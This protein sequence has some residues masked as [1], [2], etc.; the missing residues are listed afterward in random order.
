MQEDSRN[1]RYGSVVVP[2]SHVVAVL[3]LIQKE[4]LRNIRLSATC[5]ESYSVRILHRW[6]DSRPPR[7]N[8][9]P[10]VKSGWWSS[11]LW[12]TFMFVPPRQLKWISANSVSL[13]ACFNLPTSSA[14]HPAIQM[15]YL[16][17]QPHGFRRSRNLTVTGL[18]QELHVVC[19]HRHPGS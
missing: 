17:R 10:H 15:S 8:S 2:V 9:R 7:V 1:N 6:Y 19:I 5:R 16:N 3:S 12:Y 4:A 11:N 14:F 18:P 13:Q